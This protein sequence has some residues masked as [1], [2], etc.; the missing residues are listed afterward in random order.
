MK[1]FTSHTP[2][3]IPSHK[4]EGASFSNNFGFSILSKDTSEA[5]LVGAVAW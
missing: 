3:T 2:I 5:Q 1:G 4:H